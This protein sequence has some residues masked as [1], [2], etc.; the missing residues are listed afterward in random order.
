MLMMT[1]RERPAVIEAMAPGYARLFERS[2]AVLA[3]DDRVRAVWL[4]GSVARGEADAASD[5]DLIVTVDD[6]E[7]AV[8]A[9]D[10]RGWLAAI[11]DTVLAKPL[12]FA[13]GSFYAVT[14][15]WHRLDV[16]VEQVNEIPRTR[17]RARLAVLDRE[18]LSQRLPSEEPPQGPSAETVTSLVDDF[19]RSYGLLPVIVSRRDW[20]AGL[21]GIHLLRS[22]LYRLF[23]ESGAPHPVTGA[24]R[25]SEKLSDKHRR[26]LEALPTGEATRRGVIDSHHALLGAFQAHAPELCERLGVAW[27]ERFE[28]ATLAHVQRQLEELGA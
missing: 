6:R 25:V 14:P 12:G 24:K 17:Y 27:P 7:H 9:D 18:G 22:V 28:S 2:L 23:V 3:A 21:E 15:D 16:I 20:L 8:F 11:T 26:V 13:P 19:I 5:L 4:S 10:W 1:G